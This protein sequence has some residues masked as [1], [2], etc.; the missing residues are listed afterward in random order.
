MYRKSF[1]SPYKRNINSS[2]SIFKNEH[3]IV[4]HNNIYESSI[5]T[6]VFGRTDKQTAWQTGV[7]NTVQLRFKVFK[8]GNLDVVLF[9]TRW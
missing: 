9:Y 8:N 6:G 1:E 4:N 2:L 7:I 5:F 3:T